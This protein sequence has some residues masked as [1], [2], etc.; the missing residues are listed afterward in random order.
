MRTICQRLPC[1][2]GGGVRSLGRARAL[3]DAGAKRVIVGSSLFDEDGVRADG[4]RPTRRRS[5][6]TRS[7]PPSTAATG[8][9]SS[10]AGRPSSTITPEAAATALDP[11]CGA[12]L[13]TNVETEGLLGG[14]PIDRARALKAATK[15]KL[16]VAGGIRSHEEIDALDDLGV[17][18]VVGMAIYKGLIEI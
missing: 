8:T 13:Y 14:F 11:Y 7:W 17:D 6:S 3:L 15:R 1:Q 2:V 5:A 9:S 18:A 4:P 12:F 16:I 10:T